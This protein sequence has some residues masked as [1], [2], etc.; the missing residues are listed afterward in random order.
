MTK[1]QALV[2][3]WLLLAWFSLD[4]IGLCVPGFCLVEPALKEDGLFFGLYL[5]WVLA[6]IVRESIGQW[7]LTVWLGLWLITQL[8]AHEW[9]TLFGRGVMGPMAGKLEA[10]SNTL[11]W[12]DWP[13]RYVPDVYHTILHL[14]ILMALIAMIRYVHSARQR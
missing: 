13:G 14:L 5:A 11:K 3:Q 8:L 12:R 6:F 9:Y 4:M 1:R 10:F 7:L 2:F